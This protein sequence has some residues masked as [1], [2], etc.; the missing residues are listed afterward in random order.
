MSDRGGLRLQGN[1]QTGY[2]PFIIQLDQPATS[3]IR[4]PLRSSTSIS[5]TLTVAGSGLRTFG[6]LVTTASTMYLDQRPTS[7]ISIN[8]FNH[9]QSDRGGLQLQDNRQTGY[10]SFD[11]PST[12]WIIHLNY[13]STPIPTSLTVAGFG[14]RAIG[15]LVAITSIDHFD[16]PLRPPT[17]IIPTVAGWSIINHRLRSPLQPT[18]HLKH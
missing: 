8:H 4:P 1:R 7:I 14:F 16:Q 10:T 3:I 6:R 9:I 18:I 2:T 13:H 11:H 12:A 15:S 17:S 5:T